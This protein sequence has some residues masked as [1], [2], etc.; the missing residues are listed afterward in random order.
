[1]TT[2]KQVVFTARDRIEIQHNPTPEI[3]PEDLLLRV[4]RVGICATDVHV[5]EGYIGDPFPLVP[6]HEFVGEVAEIGERAARVRGLAPGDRVAVEML[7]PC[8][9]C[10]WCRRGEYNVCAED[11]VV[12][13]GSGRQYGINMGQAREPGFWGG[14]SEHLFVPGSAIVHRLD[15]RVEWDAAALV[16]PLSVAC[17]CVK[18]G[19]VT[20]GDDV[21]VIGPGPVG[22]LAAAAAKEAG[23]RRVV[24][25]GTRDVRLALGADFGVDGT[26][27]SRTSEDPVGELREALG[28]RLA[29]VVIETAGVADA[30]VQ[31][32]RM[33]RR[34]GRAV[35]AGALGSQ[36]P[37]TFLQDE[38][39]LL[40][41][42]EIVAS[43]LSAGG[44]ESAISML[45]HGS[46]PFAE[47]V[48]HRFPLDRVA[49]AMDVVRHKKDGVLKAVL[50]PQL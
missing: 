18:R 8:G 2:S 22:L 48:T 15:E 14:Y 10:E 35:L 17:R 33:T 1:M 40:R 19:R 43:F 12:H 50:T 26:V 9:T 32:V 25:V 20:L 6:G 3:G 13:G 4:H 31:A 24:L 21:A 11:D 37:V 29:D 7:L 30:Q 5:L 46:Y 34:G 23:A 42:V 41:D 45:E 39:I 44:Y 36:A 28:G 16:E 47:L 49:D 27:N 38:D